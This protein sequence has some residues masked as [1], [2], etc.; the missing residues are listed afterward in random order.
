M[1]KLA[2]A[3]NGV[4]QLGLDTA[5][6]IYFVEPIHG[7]VAEHAADLRARYVLRPPDALQIATALHA[8]CTDFLTNDIRLQ[9]VT[10]IRVL[11]LDEIEL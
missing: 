5:P 6:F 11:V 7:N 1:I 10:E 9:R 4:T 3:L 8:G 2:V